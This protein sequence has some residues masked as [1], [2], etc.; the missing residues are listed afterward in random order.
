MKGIILSEFVEFLEDTVG[1][2]QAQ[3]IIDNSGVSSGGAYSRVG[4]YDYQELIQLLTQAVTD[5]EHETSFLLQA[6]S[7]HLFGVFKR[8]YQVFFDGVSSAAQMLSQIDNHIHVEVKKLY[9]D[10]ELPKFEYQTDG[11]QFTLD[12]QSPRPLAAVAQAL[13]NAC[14]KYFGNREELVSC[15]IAEDQ[16]AAKFV[17]QL[18]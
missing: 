16:C 5:T 18:I 13:V 12:Y 1:P 14:I 2:E 15:E 10:A 4:Q 17:I 6:F 7:D 3:A 11:K 9:P 8:D